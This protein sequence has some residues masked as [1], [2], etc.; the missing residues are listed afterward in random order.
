MLGISHRVESSDGSPENDGVTTFALALGHNAG[1]GG[2]EVWIHCGVRKM[3]QNPHKEEEFEI[4]CIDR[5]FLWQAI[6]RLSVCNK[7]WRIGARPSISHERVDLPL[8]KCF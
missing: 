4:E 3:K 6:L 7:S 2:S 5:S 8:R 1:G